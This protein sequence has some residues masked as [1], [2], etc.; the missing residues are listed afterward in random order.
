MYKRQVLDRL[1]PEI[2]AIEVGRGNSYGHPAPST[3]SALR[4]AG[5]T[6]YRTDQDGTVSLTVKH[7]EM[8]VTTE[9]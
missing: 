2:A 8:H 6:T 5:V 1:R 4:H 7:G 3:V 9:H